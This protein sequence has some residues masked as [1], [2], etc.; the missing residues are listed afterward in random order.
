MAGGKPRYRIHPAIGIARVGNAP[1]DEFFIGP[2]RPG[3]SVTGESGAGTAVPAF[4]DGGLVR[5]KAARFRIFEY[6][7]S[8]GVWTVSREIT[9][10]DADTLTWTVHLANRKA[11][12][13]EF[14]GLAGSPL[15]KKQPSHERRNK[16][17]K[18]RRTLDIDPLPRSISGRGAKP[19]EFHKGKSASPKNESPKKELWPTTAPVLDYLGE[20]RTDPAERLIVLGGTGRVYQAPGAAALYSTFNNDGWFDDVWRPWLLP[21]ARTCPG[22]SATTRITSWAPCAG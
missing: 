22:C 13:F 18:N 1:A 5:R 2:E 3:Q 7:E 19:V 9:A 8:G 20:L 12:F 14:K 4:K 21:L 6:V 11:S 17:V 15:L 16:S 10:A